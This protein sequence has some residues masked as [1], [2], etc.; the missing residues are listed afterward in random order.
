M[1]SR[2][3][4]SL[5]VLTGVAGA[6]PRTLTSTY[7]EAETRHM[8]G[9]RGANNRNIDLTIT[10]TLGDKGKLG[11]MAVGKDNDHWLD[12]ITGENTDTTT[13]WTTSW[14]GTWKQSGDR[15]VLS[16]VLAGQTCTKQ[17]TSDRF[18]TKKLK[19]DAPSKRARVMC[20]S[21]DVEVDGAKA[22]ETA[23]R[24]RTEQGALGETYPYWVAGKNTC[25]KT[26]GGRM[27]RSYAPC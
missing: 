11:V 15:L 18:A 21:E 2:A 27:H 24:C 22:K 19:C 7:Q 5:L 8:A 14:T 26:H 10:I 9:Q 3:V 4:L 20:D 16:L 12:G 6:A 23:W 17:E 13:T 25:L 1:R